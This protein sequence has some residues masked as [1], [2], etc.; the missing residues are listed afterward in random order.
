MAAS[1]G[2]LVCGPRAVQVLGKF[3]PH[4]DTAVYDALVRLAQD[5]SMRHPLVRALH[6]VPLRPVPLHPHPRQSSQALRSVA[7][8]ERGS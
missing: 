4:G 6:P 2:A 7:K 3:H 8:R 5:F 1:P